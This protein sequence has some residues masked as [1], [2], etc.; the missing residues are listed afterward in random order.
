M[1]KKVTVD[2]DKLKTKLFDRY[3]EKFRETENEDEDAMVIADL[4]ETDYVLTLMTTLD[5]SGGE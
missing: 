5:E 2:L 1:G 3:V 4:M